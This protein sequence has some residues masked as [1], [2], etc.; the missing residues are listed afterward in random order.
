MQL[1]ATT[2][3]Q[4]R[5]KIIICY[6]G[7]DYRTNTS[8]NNKFVSAALFDQ[9]LR[10]LKQH[11]NIITLKQYVENDVVPDR[12]NVAITFDDGFRNNYT[13]ARPL[14]EKYN[15]PATFFI[16]PIWH[17][18]KNI[19]WPDLVDQVTSNAPRTI[20]IA[21]EQYSKGLNG[22]FFHSTGLPIHHHVIKQNSTFVNYLYEVLLPYAAFMQKTDMDVYWQLMS[23]EETIALSQNPLFTIGSHTYTHTSLI[24]LSKEEA[25]QELTVSRSVLENLVQKPVD[26]FAAPFGHFNSDTI[27]YARHA[28][29]TFQPMDTVDR[30]VYHDTDIVSRFAVNPYISANDQLLFISKGQY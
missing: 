13:L 23:P 12:L 16:T 19:L 22:R 5:G 21:G 14:L 11:T 17:Q 25:M 26:Y 20:E 24:H 6:H 15:A 4:A 9:H 1:P 2:I 28:G 8:V 27:V 30:T 29:Y 18:G 3:Q 7:V 10:L